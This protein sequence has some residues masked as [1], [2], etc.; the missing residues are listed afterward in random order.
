MKCLNCGKEIPEGRKFCSRSCAASYNN[1]RRERKPWTEEQHIKNRKPR[2]EAVCKYCGKPGKTICDECRP[3][4]QKVPTFRKAGILEGSL[5]QRYDQLI[6]LI[7]DLHLEG[8]CITEICR[9]LNIHD[10]TVRQILKSLG[11]RLYTLSEVQTRMYA[12][13]FREISPGRGKY[14]TGNH[15]SWE[16]NTFFCRSSYELEFA[17]SLDKQQI[18]YRMEAFRIPYWDTAKQRQR[19]AI[20]DFYLPETNELVEI[21]STWTYDEQNMKDRFKAFRKQGFIPILVLDKMRR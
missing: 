1:V 14:K 11:L 3:Y 13:G 4:V 7:E 18:P 12:E 17:E 8:H 21:K 19:I 16:G 5:K 9:E 6:N 10:V 15:T 20:P 2:E